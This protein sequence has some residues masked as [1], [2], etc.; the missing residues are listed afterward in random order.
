MSLIRFSPPR[1]GRA[2]EP[3]G[4]RPTQYLTRGINDHAIRPDSE[5][6]RG[7]A[8]AFQRGTVDFC[9]YVTVS[10]PLDNREMATL[11][12]F[13]LAMASPAA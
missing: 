6:Q 1:V 2:A 7:A 5:Q 8:L 9:H 4:A 10:V 3:R 11:Y 13:F 12:A